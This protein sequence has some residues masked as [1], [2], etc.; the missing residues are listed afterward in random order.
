MILPSSLQNRMPSIYKMAP[1]S[2]TPAPTVAPPPA[3]DEVAV[4]TTTARD[5]ALLPVFDP[6]VG[7]VM[8][9]AGLALGMGGAAPVGAAMQPAL[10]GQ[11][12]DQQA[13]IRYSINSLGMTSSGTLSGTGAFTGNVSERLV[14]SGES[15]AHLTGHI[16]DD[17]EDLTL[18][19]GVDGMHIAGTVGSVA[20]DLTYG[21]LAPGAAPAG[22][23]DADADYPWATVSGT[24]GGSTYNATATMS[25]PSQV[26]DM[27][28]ISVRGAL[29][30]AAIDKTYRVT[31]DA[32]SHTLTI[33]GH[34]T[35]AGSKQ[36]MRLVV[37]LSQAGSSG[38]VLNGMLQR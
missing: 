24:I 32:D 27:A 36:D 31:G 29:D 6:A 34:G 11:L 13:Q 2:S 14:P 38:S 35:L 28:A 12:G 22:A 19:V 1:Q 7:A 25:P 26:G 21:L 30:Q 5:V 15:T 9:M 20:V 37:D 3:R 4:R 8:V 16:G 17:A 10:S 23:G 18:S 33:D